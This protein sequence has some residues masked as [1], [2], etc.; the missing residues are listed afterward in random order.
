MFNIAPGGGREYYWKHLFGKSKIKGQNGKN[1]IIND[2]DIFKESAYRKYKISS[3]QNIFYFDGSSLGGLTSSGDARKKL[4]KETAKKKLASLL[5]TM[6]GKKYYFISHSEGGAFASGIAEYLVENGIEVGEHITLS[7]DEADK[8]EAHP[9]VPTYQLTPMYFTK[10]DKVLKELANYAR[11]ASHSQQ[12]KKY[13]NYY[14]IVDW[15]VGDYQLKNSK[16]YGIIKI[17]EENVDW[18]TLHTY[19]ID[20]RLFEW[21]DDLKE[22]ILFVGVNTSQGATKNKT[23]FYKINDTFVTNN[24]PK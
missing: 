17:N 4:G 18:T 6:K 15:M 22:V 20:K 1:K 8:F 10:D 3:N 11:F 9:K 13:G 24:I 21:I 12:I 14:A 23:N 2:I 5:G 16:K 7:C 19:L